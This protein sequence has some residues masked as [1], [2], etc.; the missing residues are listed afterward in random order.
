MNF[1]ADLHTHTVSSTHAY[2]T[3][4]E[5]ARV[6]ADRGLQYLAITDHSSSDVCDAP[7]VWHFHNIPRAVDRV[8]FGV[9]MLFGAEVSITDPDGGVNMAAEDLLYLDWVVASVHFPVPGIRDYTGVY[10]GAAYNPLIDVIGHSAHERFFY[11]Y[12]T[13]L[14]LFADNHKL[15][16]INDSQIIHRGRFDAYVK[17]AEKCKE[18][19]VSVVVN[20]DAHFC[21]RVGDHEGGAAV[22]EAVGFPEE[23]VVNASAENLENYLKLRGK[24][25]LWI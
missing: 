18:H 15:V 7:H 3:I 12:D 19:G 24:N 11:D 21:N 16:E 23:L 8:L 17:L 13:V 6:A 20:S 14:P 9:K 22:L 10:T 25:L 5:N 1:I 4:L 2:S